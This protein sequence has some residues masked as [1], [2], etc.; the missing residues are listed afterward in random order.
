MKSLLGLTLLLTLSFASLA[1]E[2]KWEKYTTID[3]VEIYTMESDCYAKN[4][5]AQKAILIKV[6]NTTNQKLKIEWDRAIWYNDK[7][8]TENSTDGE[9]HMVIEID[10]NSSQ[11]GSCDVP[12]GALY[13][14]KDFITYE[15]ETKLSKF[16]LQNIKV[17]RL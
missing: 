9:N 3:G 7:L 17:S 5:P 12:R 4:I 14:Y 8:V 2:S 11:E 10:K 1:Q 16:E 15:T 13:L 6:V